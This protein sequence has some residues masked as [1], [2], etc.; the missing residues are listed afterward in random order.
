MTSSVRQGTIEELEGLNEITPFG[1]VMYRPLPADICVK[2]TN[3]LNNLKIPALIAADLEHGG[4]I[5]QPNGTLFG[6]QLAAAKRHTG[7]AGLSHT[8]TYQTFRDSLEHSSRHAS[9]AWS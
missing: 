3:Y 5:I 6:A 2:L 9:P 8:S 1:G 7:P 4:N